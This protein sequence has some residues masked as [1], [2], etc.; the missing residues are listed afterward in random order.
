MESS[1]LKLY[2]MYDDELK[3]EE[4]LPAIP[5]PE[6]PNETMEFLA[7]SWSLSA[8]EVSKALETKQIDTKLSPIH[9][10]LVGNRSG[11]I[12]R[13]VIGRLFHHK[14]CEKKDKARMENARA[15][16]LLSVAGLA[17]A[18]AAATATESFISVCSKTSM[19]LTSATRLLASY[20][21]ELA[22]SGGADK[23]CVAS[24]IRSALA[25]RPATDLLT[26]TAAAATGTTYYF[27]HLISRLYIHTY[28]SP[29][30]LM[31]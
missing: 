27:I 30:I 15:H 3:E 6:T 16:A 5:Q 1:K 21:I 20:C 9:Q 23:E 25:I 10:N 2:I 18:L 22:E 4:S 24:T 12:N 29:N 31:Q 13:R 7:R 11:S 17:V 26:L 8:N 19:A 14:L 28:I